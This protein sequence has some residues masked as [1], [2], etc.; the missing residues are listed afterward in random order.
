MPLLELPHTAGCL[1]CGRDNPHGLNLSSFVDPDA[2]T[3]TTTFTPSP[4]HIGFESIIHGGILATVLDE[5]MV[6]TAIWATGKACVAAE[7]SLRFIE[8]AGIGRPLVCTAK[9][10]RQRSRLIE[11]SA[12]IYDGPALICTA[13]GKYAPL[14]SAETQAFLKTFIDDAGTRQAAEKLRA[15]A[16][17]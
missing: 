7:L 5:L 17:R 9:I 14:G 12:E 13:T 16:C 8:K 1:V 3:V 2:G 6:W 4:H 15:T 11:T 10:T